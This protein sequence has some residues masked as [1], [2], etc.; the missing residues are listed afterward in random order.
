VW[1]RVIKEVSAMFH[2]LNGTDTVFKVAA[3]ASVNEGPAALDLCALTF[4]LALMPAHKGRLAGRLAH[5][6]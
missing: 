6:A 4:R 1:A 3:T 5:E 2:G